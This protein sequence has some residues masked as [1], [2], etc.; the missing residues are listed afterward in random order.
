MKKILFFVIVVTICSC[1]IPK[2]LFNPSGGFTYKYDGQYTGLD[3][4]LNIQGYYI[5]PTSIVNVGQSNYNVKFFLNGLYCSSLS[6]DSI[7]MF[8]DNSSYIY[9]G[10]YI[11]SGDT[12][13]VQVVDDEGLL[14]GIRTIYVSYQIVSKDLIK[15]LNSFEKPESTMIYQFKPT[16]PDPFLPD[17]WLL[18]K[19]WFWKKGYYPKK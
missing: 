11:L 4:L 7:N 14:G 9:W 1:T 16:M 19:K 15:R 2:R 12:I 6:N 8:D 10:R 5:Y 18:K 13:K 17:C 3:T